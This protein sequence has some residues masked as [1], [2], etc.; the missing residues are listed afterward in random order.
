MF[1]Y[2]DFY[3]LCG[4]EKNKKGPL[5]S[6]SNLNKPYFLRFSQQSALSNFASSFR[7]C[8]SFPAD[9]ARRRWC[10]RCSPVC[11]IR[12]PSSLPV[13]QISRCSTHRCAQEDPCFWLNPRHGFHP[14]GRPR[15]SRL[16]GH[17]PARRKCSSPYKRPD[18]FHS[19]TLLRRVPGSVF[20]SLR[21][22]LPYLSTSFSCYLPHFMLKCGR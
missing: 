2:C 19:A 20:I 7:R 21:K 22:N 1:A 9:A 5:R 4:Q 11:R 14:Y 15:R 8:G 12:R 6:I 17:F 3:R 16:S 10:G 18:Y 13:Q